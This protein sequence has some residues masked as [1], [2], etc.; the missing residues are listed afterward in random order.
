MIS[1]F[2]FIFSLTF[3][4]LGA[5]QIAIVLEHA[6]TEEQMMWGLMQ[7]E[8]LPENQG[9]LFHYPCAKKSS[10]WMFNCLIDLSVA[11]L[12]SEGKILEIYELKAYP[13]KMDPKRPVYSIDHLTKLYPADDPILSFFRKNKVVST[14][15]AHYCLEMNA[16]WFKEHSVKPGDF[17][18]WDE[19]SG[20]VFT[21]F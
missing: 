12:D 17:V 3:N 4:S 14:L 2:L 1:I 20:T 10:I 21:E 19:K 6:K 8:S 11:F 9:M 18:T 5:E 15:P 16:H 13:E 7:R